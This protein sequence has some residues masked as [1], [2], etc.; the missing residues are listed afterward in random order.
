MRDQKYYNINLE[1]GTL[2]YLGEHDDYC[3]ADEI[4]EQLPS[5]IRPGFQWLLG[6]DEIIKIR[7]SCNEVIDGW[8][9]EFLEE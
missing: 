1:D 9:R 7:N 2:L 5:T 6:P 8:V 4:M 3:S